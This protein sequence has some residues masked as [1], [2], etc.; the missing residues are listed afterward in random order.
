MFNKRRYA[1]CCTNEKTVKFF[2]IT[3]VVEFLHLLESAKMLSSPV[4]FDE[5]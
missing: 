5:H 3:L 1:I 2:Y 4:E